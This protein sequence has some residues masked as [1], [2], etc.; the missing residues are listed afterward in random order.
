MGAKKKFLLGWLGFEVLGLIIAIP[1]GSQIADKVMF[2]VAP[3]AAKAPL[4]NTPGK[5]GFIVASNAPF[6]IISEG[7]VGDMRVNLTVAGNINGTVFGSNAQS[8]GHPLLC[9]T[10]LSSGPNIIYKANR[11]TAANRGPVLDQS[12]IIEINY[13]PSLTPKFRLET[14]DKPIV[15]EAI[16]APTCG[17]SSA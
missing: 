11:K 3:R 14:L 12:V 9:V 10:A 1:A 2:S 5:S 6:A 16:L 15:K 4:P 17:P 7:V 13:D 8:P